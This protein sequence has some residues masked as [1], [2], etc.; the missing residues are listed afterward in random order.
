MIEERFL[1]GGL[2]VA[3][4]G[5][6]KKAFQAGEPTEPMLETS[7][8]RRRRSLMSERAVGARIV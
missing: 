5:G 6:Q 1:E 4:M 2:G 3:R 8:Y 7:V